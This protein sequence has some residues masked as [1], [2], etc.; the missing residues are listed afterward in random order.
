[1]ADENLPE[2]PSLT[3]PVV[4]QIPTYEFDVAMIIDDT[5][6]QII[7]MDGP[8]AAQYLSSPSFVQVAHG[9]VKVGWIHHNGVFSPPTNQSGL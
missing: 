3:Y 1:M 6:F 2:V 5:V 8:T 9:E 7:N 4:E